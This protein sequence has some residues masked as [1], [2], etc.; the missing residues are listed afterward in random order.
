M[1]HSRSPSLHD[2]R[3]RPAYP[4]APG[5]TG[6]PR[7]Q[8]AGALY[9]SPHACGTARPVPLLNCAAA[10]Q[11]VWRPLWFEFPGA[12][13]AFATDDQFLLGPGVLVAPVVKAAAA[14]RPVLL[15]GP[16]PWYHVGTGARRLHHRRAPAAALQPGQVSRSIALMSQGPFSQSV[17]MFWEHAHSAAVCKKHV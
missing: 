13:G 16:H 15:P 4:R 12:E 3:G 6:E 2:R 1:L 14:S 7:A 5:G 17:W 11:P 9:V 10:G 8:H